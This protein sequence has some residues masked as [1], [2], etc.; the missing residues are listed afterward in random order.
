MILQCQPDGNVFGLWT[1]AIPLQEIG[2]LKMTRASNVEFNESTQQ[3]EVRLASNPD[4]VAFA[5][6]SRAK[7]IA[8][9]IATLDNQIMEGA[10]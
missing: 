10:L 2:A 5:N 8:W 3:W 6:P 7:C 1:D 4:R 9:E